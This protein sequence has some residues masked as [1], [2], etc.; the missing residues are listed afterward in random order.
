VAKKKQIT[1]KKAPKNRKS[2]LTKRA[3]AELCGLTTRKLA[4]YIS[5]ENVKADSKGL[6]DISIDINSEFLRKWQELSK[7]EQPVKKAADILL[8]E[9][10]IKQVE[11]ATK[12]RELQAARLAGETVPTEMAKAVLKQH[13]LSVMTSFKNAADRI[14]GDVTRRKNF[15]LEEIAQLNG[16]IIAAI[17]SAVREAIEISISSLKNIEDEYSQKRERGQ[18]D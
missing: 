12:Y 15:S 18:R 3:F 16:E 2:K 11:A 5:R 8:K 17:N 6:I 9:A 4:T 13:N 10:R 7:G 1:S 14:V